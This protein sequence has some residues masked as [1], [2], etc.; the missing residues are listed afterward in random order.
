MYRIF[1]AWVFALSVFCHKE[2]VNSKFFELSSPGAQKINEAK[3]VRKRLK[4]LFY[5]TSLSYSRPYV[6][7]VSIFSWLLC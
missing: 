7:L 5:N 6:I 3:G 1:Y 2:T 4:G